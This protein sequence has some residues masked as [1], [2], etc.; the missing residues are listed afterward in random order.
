M[1]ASKETYTDANP[2]T[3]PLDYNSL[4]EDRDLQIELFPVHSPLL[5]ESYSFSFPPLTYMLKLSG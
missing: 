4:S 3:A 5:R 1:P 2:G